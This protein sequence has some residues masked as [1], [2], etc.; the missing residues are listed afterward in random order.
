[1]KEFEEYIMLDDNDEILE[2]WD[3]YACQDYI[4]YRLIDKST[5]HIIMEN[6]SAHDFI[7]YAIDNFLSGVAYAEDDPVIVHRYIIMPDGTEKHC[8]TKRF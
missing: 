8:Y 7:D 6:D 2:E 1:M 3:D 4:K 5:N